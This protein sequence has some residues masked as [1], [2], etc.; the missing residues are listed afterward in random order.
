[1]GWDG[2]SP[3]VPAELAAA[4]IQGRVRHRMPGPAA[5]L[6]EDEDRALPI[7]GGWCPEDGEDPYD[8]VTSG[9]CPHTPDHPTAKI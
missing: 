5:L 4:H 9:T 3:L 6:G 2:G 7:S 1:M 8:D